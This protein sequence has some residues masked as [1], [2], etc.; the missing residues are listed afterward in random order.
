MAA[1][2]MAGEYIY[3]YHRS[4]STYRE[5]MRVIYIYVI[6]L[7]DLTGSVFSTRVC[8]LYTPPCGVLLVFAHATQM[9]TLGTAAVLL[10]ICGVRNEG[11]CVKGGGREGKGGS[12]VMDKRLP[13]EY[14]ILKVDLGCNCTVRWVDTILFTI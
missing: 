11:A 1:C 3:M 10:V 6:I 7:A 8:I 2:Y 4:T 14:V 13:F 12:D 5:V 9:L